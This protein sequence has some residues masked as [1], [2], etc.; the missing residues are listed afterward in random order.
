MSSTE[1]K[2]EEVKISTKTWI[3]LTL[4]IVV[5][6]A[7]IT[8]ETLFLPAA[9]GTGGINIGP[10]GGLLVAMPLPYVFAVIMLLL[11]DRGIVKISKTTFALLYVAVMISTWYSVYKGFYTTPAALYNIRIST[12]D[13][14]T[15]PPIIHVGLKM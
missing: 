9:W 12:A 15:N 4:F 6:T 5:L 13:T 8:T 11:M 2:K 3:Y 14:P 7:L 1:T 10:S